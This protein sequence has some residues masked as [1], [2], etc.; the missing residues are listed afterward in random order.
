MARESED[1]ARAQAHNAQDEA[2]REQ[3]RLGPILVQRHASVPEERV[4]CPLERHHGTERAEL[5]RADASGEGGRRVHRWQ[6]R[7]GRRAGATGG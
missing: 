6:C 1:R 3:S 7:H 2:A 5:A 4:G